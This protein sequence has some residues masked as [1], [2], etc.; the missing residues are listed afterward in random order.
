MFG[1]T[2]THWFLS[3]VVCAVHPGAQADQHVA[4]R[5]LPSTRRQVE[6]GL[7]LLKMS[8]KWKLIITH[9]KSISVAKINR[10]SR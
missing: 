9:D 1:K 8:K 7:F 6:G 5:L 3:E 4:S 2:E 10:D